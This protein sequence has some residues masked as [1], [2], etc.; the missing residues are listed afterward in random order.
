MG[1]KDVRGRAYGFAVAGIDQ[2]KA[3]TARS[4]LGP[5]YRLLTSLEQEG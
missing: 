3:P 5:S 4:A 2:Q 1:M